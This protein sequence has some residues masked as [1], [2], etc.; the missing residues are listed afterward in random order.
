MRIESIW[1]NEKIH[2]LFLELKAFLLDLVLYAL[3]IELNLFNGIGLLSEDIVSVGLRN[4]DYFL[5]GF[6]MEKELP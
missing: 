3:E 2:T 4:F 5:G 6:Y 1:L